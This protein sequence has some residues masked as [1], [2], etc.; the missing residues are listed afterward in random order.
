MASLPSG[1]PEPN[2]L[3][4]PTHG[5]VLYS[6]LAASPI[7]LSLRGLACWEPLAARPKRNRG[8]S[9]W[10]DWLTNRTTPINS[11]IWGCHSVAYGGVLAPD[12]P[13][14]PQAA[15]QSLGLSLQANPQ[16]GESSGG[17]LGVSSRY[18][19]RWWDW[20]WKSLASHQ[21]PGTSPIPPHCRPWRRLR[22]GPSGQSVFAHWMTG[23]SWKPLAAIPK[24][25]PGVL[26]LRDQIFGMLSFP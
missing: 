7:I 11:A 12:W 1:R 22:F 15:C 18:Q 14:E 13:W 23:P 25:Q 26:L 6:H 8:L 9:Y 2:T 24:L 19:L 21:G 5:G 17:M 16:T 3:S 4:H 10:S 20:R